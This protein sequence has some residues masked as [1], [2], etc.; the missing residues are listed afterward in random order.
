MRKK[1]TII[2]AAAANNAIGK[3]NALLWHLP[4][5]LKRFKAL[6]SGHAIIMGRK[7]FESLPKALPNRTNIVITRNTAYTAEAAVVCSS[8][9]AALKIAATDPQPFIIGGG[10]IYNQALPLSDQLELTR[11]HKDYQ[12]DTFFP[13][14][15]PKQW[16]LVNEENHAGESEVIPHSYL[17]YQR[18]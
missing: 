13:E 15:D 3:D 6:T 7:T 12:G 10:E 4:E 2:V 18:K 8:L 16:E 14:I 11:I 5:D 17:T 9:E 1:I